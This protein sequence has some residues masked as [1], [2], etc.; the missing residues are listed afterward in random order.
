[1]RIVKSID[2]VTEPKLKD[3]Q[4]YIYVIRNIP[5]SNI[6]IGRTKDPK[7][8]FSSLSGSNSGGNNLDIFAISEPTYVYFLERMAHDHFARERIPNTEWFSGDDISFLE[9]VDY[10]EKIFNTESYKRTNERVKS[11]LYLLNKDLEES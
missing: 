7:Q 1:M 5:Q 2:L 4:W 11:Y 6:K 10:L 9:V 3:N 8:R